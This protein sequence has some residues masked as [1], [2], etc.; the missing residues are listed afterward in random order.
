LVDWPGYPLVDFPD[1]TAWFLKNLYKTFNAMYE[2]ANTKWVA[3]MGSDTFFSKNWLARLMEAAD[4]K[5]ERAV[6]HTWCVESPVAKRSR[7]DIQDWGS[8]WQTFDLA[9]FELYAAER[10]WRWQ[11]QLVIPGEESGLFFN[12]PARGMQQRADSVTWLQTK[13]LWEEYG[14]LSDTINAEGVTGD[15][16]FM[17]ALTDAGIKQYLVPS[18]TA[19]HAV[20]GESRGVQQ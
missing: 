4:A 14:P 15:V 2:L 11:N 12:H 13:A 6:Y 8:T 1:K 16:S 5:G 7:H 10:A 3:R 9:R 20:R 17:D 19:W 18:V